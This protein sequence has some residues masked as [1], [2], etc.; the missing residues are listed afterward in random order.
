MYLS[1][2]TAAQVHGAGA[3]LGGLEPQHDGG[4]EFVVSS[5]TAGLLLLEQERRRAMRREHE[6]VFDFFP[7]RK[8][9]EWTGSN[10]NA[11]IFHII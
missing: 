1:G 10:S 4:G 3:G 8:Q 2:E 5:T 7:P 11:K 9:K 6:A